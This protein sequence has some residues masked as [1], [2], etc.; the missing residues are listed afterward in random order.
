MRTKMLMAAGLLLALPVLAAPARTSPAAMMKPEVLTEAQA[1]WK[2]IQATLGQVPTFMRAMPDEA[3]AG[4]WQ[5]MKD[6]QL[7]PNTALSPMA[8]ELIGLGVSAQIPCKYCVYFHTEAARANGATD[9]DIKEALAIAAL[10][11]HWSTL[12]NGLQVD[13]ANFRS[14]V[15]RMVTHVKSMM[16]PNPAM[17]PAQTRIATANDVYADMEAMFGFVPAFAKMLPPEA[18][19][20]AWKEVKAISF[21][22]TALPAKLKDAISI[23]VSAQVPCRYCLYM[24]QQF[25]MKIDGLSERELREAVAM[26]ALVRHWSTMLNGAQVD[27]AKFKREVDQVFARARRA[28]VQRPAGPA[29]KRT[30]QVQPQMKTLD[31]LKLERPMQPRLD[32]S[33]VR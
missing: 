18:I 24:D 33:D 17:A 30:P 20:G 23:A 8:K 3:I 5:E 12:L 27:E 16:A 11:R 32:D 26:S 14:E 19:V 4:A 1:A 15:D 25:G 2:D 31:R 22:E 7:N 10:E 28:Q 21:S 9:R 13:E 29:L 6:L